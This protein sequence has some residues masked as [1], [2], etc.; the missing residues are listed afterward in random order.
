MKRLE[1]DIRNLVARSQCGRCRS[2]GPLIAD[3]VRVKSLLPSGKEVP[4]SQAE[5]R[6]HKAVVNI[7]ASSS[8]CMWTSVIISS[9]VLNIVHA[10]FNRG[11]A[12]A[13]VPNSHSAQVTFLPT[14]LSGYTYFFATGPTIERSAKLIMDKLPDKNAR[15]VLA[16]FDLDVF[17]AGVI[18]HISTVF[19][20]EQFSAITTL[21]VPLGFLV[22]GDIHTERFQFIRNLARLLNAAHTLNSP[23]H[24]DTVPQVDAT[25]AL[26]EFH[27]DK[28]IPGWRKRANQPAYILF[29]EQL[30]GKPVW[31][32]GLRPLPNVMD[33]EQLHGDI[34][35]RLVTIEIELFAAGEHLKEVLSPGEIFLHTYLQRTSPREL[36]AQL[37]EENSGLFGILN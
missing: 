35:R 33:D 14:A 24:V 8:P 36:V 19:A 25:L 11:L 15:R 2:L 22:D 10:F 13:V 34:F 23:A 18:D 32:Q 31:G 3:L 6:L 5:I 12:S 21:R 1:K 20:S 17:D 30:H 29:D 28:T 9:S 4:L 37:R 16:I 27:R 26:M 7:C